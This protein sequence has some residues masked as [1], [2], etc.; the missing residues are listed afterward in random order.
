M[1]G[2]CLPSS[3]TWKKLF[4]K[5]NGVIT[6]VGLILLLS[7]GIPYVAYM[8][9]TVVRPITN[10]IP[11]WDWPYSNIILFFSLCTMILAGIMCRVKGLEI[12]HRR[13]TWG[14]LVGAALLWFVSANPYCGD[15]WSQLP[16]TILFLYASWCF[17]IALL[18]PLSFLVC[19]VILLFSFIEYSTSLTGI[20]F[21]EDTF[22]QIF[23]TTWTD[24]KTYLTFFNITLIIAAVVVSCVLYVPVYVCLRRSKFWVLILHASVAF[25]LF[26]TAL[27][28]LETHLQ[29][30][31][32]YVWPLGIFTE[33]GSN[34]GRA[35]I[36]IHRIQKYISLLPQREETSIN[37]S[38]LT[39]DEGVICFLHV[40]ESL[41]ADHCS[42]N[43]YERE[44]CPHLHHHPDMINF[45]DCISVASATDKAMLAILTDCRRNFLDYTRNEQ[46]QISGSL[47]DY[48]S[49]AHFTCLSYWGPGTIESPKK[50]IGMQT[51]FF[52]RAAE[53][54]VFVP[55]NSANQLPCIKEDLDALV[56][57][58]VF[59]LINNR[60][61]HA[62]FE[63]YNLSDPPFTPTRILSA[64]DSPRP[65]TDPA[66]KD[67]FINA[68]DN[69]VHHTDSFIHDLLTHFKGRPFVYIYISDHGEY[70]G[71]EGYWMRGNAP[72][73]AY[74]KG[75]ACQVPFFIIASPEFEALH[76]HFHEALEELRKHRD[77]STGH[78]HIFHTVLGLFGIRTSAYSQEL[79]LCSPKVQQYT[80][81]HPSR[82]GKELQQ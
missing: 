46:H 10:G 52:C 27:R 16:L 1:I 49:G 58:N 17:A 69:T 80:G 47:M 64:N 59:V 62:F 57:K 44:T 11:L 9:Q 55:G 39:K 8:H 6:I 72:H 29:V 82:A 4:S 26:L 76:P 40:G 68:Y 74:F 32:R 15:M 53:K 60:G 78:E 35:T 79:D 54:K 42:F 61:S 65:G 19:L 77:M 75:G 43:G 33:I 18:R 41:R 21:T 48:F 56:Q 63:D 81:P 7:L 34:I 24:A 23:S 3:V 73:D 37:G 38:L 28:P 13:K 51:A 5:K 12:N 71:K 66:I 25:S 36:S 45:P 20:L 70:L 30:G 22:M 50:L 31:S 14:V 2:A 67:V